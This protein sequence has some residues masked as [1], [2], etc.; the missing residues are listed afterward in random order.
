MVCAASIAWICDKFPM[1]LPIIGSLFMSGA[2][3]V[4]VEYSVWNSNFGPVYLAQVDYN[5]IGSYT[6]FDG[7]LVLAEE[8]EGSMNG[9]WLQPQSEVTCATERHGTRH[10]GR[11][12]FALN[13]DASS[14]DGTWAFCDGP[15][16]SANSWVGSV[17]LRER[18]L[19][20]SDR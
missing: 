7:T 5:V 2:A 6:D 17:V 11:V 18:R 20:R 14:F 12:A 15:H 13:R 19:V 4:D 3:S 10:W 8:R 9:I 1:L 16:D